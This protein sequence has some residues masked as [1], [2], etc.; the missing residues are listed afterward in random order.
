MGQQNMVHLNKFCGKKLEDDT[1][2]SQTI[3]QAVHQGWLQPRALCWDLDHPQ[4][5]FT[6]ITSC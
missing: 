6:S 3:K 2:N 1:D 4:W 5:T